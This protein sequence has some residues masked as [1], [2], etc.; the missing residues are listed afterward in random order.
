MSSTCGCNGTCKHQEEPAPKGATPTAEALPTNAATAPAGLQAE[1]LSPGKGLVQ[2]GRKGEAMQAGKGLTFGKSCRCDAELRPS[3]SSDRMHT[4]PQESMGFISRGC[5]CDGRFE[6]G[7]AASTFLAPGNARRLSGSHDSPLFG[8]AYLDSKIPFSA[9]VSGI[10][11]PGDIISAQRQRI[12]SMKARMDALCTSSS[13]DTM[14]VHLKDYLQLAS[15]CKISL[16]PYWDASVGTITASV[17][18]GYTPKTSAS[19]MKWD[20]LPDWMAKIHPNSREACE[21]EEEYLIRMLHPMKELSWDAVGDTITWKDV[22]KRTG[23]FWDDDGGFYYHFIQHSIITLYG[24]ASFSLSPSSV[25]ELCGF[26]SSDNPIRDVLEMRPGNAR[27]FVVGKDLD[28]LCEEHPEMEFSVANGEVTE[29]RTVFPNDDTTAAWKHWWFRNIHI[30]NSNQLRA[31]LCDYYFWWAHRLHSFSLHDAPDSLTAQWAWWVGMLCAKC[32]LSEIVSFSAVL[33]HEIGH[34]RTYWNDHCR[35][36]ESGYQQACCNYIMEEIYKE[37]TYAEMGLPCAFREARRIGIGMDPAD[38][39]TEDIEHFETRRFANESWS[40]YFYRGV[41]EDKCS[42]MWVLSQHCRL[43]DKKHRLSVQ[44]WHPGECSEG[45]NR[46]TVDFHRDSSPWC[47]TIDG[48]LQS[49]ELNPTGSV[50]IGVRGGIES[51][52]PGTSVKTYQNGQLEKLRPYRPD[53]WSVR[54]G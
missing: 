42:G 13:I 26:E 11:N 17:P 47:S 54:S 15:I 40:V 6:T 45:S 18:P 50:Y 44:Y 3:S 19:S 43:L 38:V 23:L 22:P 8:P 41:S 12:E 30:C 28:Y 53:D 46:G 31:A 4:L 7:P 32:A 2:E 34:F 48:F 51:P 35:H 39:R 33:L 21:T 36:G 20:F 37:R 49:E 5:T 25:A 16:G 27:L 14:T 24:F 52:V 29:L 10:Q 9:R 1:Y